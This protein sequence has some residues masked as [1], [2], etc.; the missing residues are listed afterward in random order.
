[1]AVAVIMPRQGQ[2]VESCILTQ[3]F[4][5]VG[6]VVS[7]GDLLFGYETDKAAF[8]EESP[9]DGILLA[10]YFEEGDEVPVLSN[11]AVIGKKGE[12]TESFAPEKGAASKLGTASG[13]ETGID[14]AQEADSTA[15][16][17]MAGQ[18]DASISG[19][20]VSGIS[21]RAR[22]L[23]REKRIQ[24]EFITGTGPGGRIIERDILDEISRGKRLTPLAQKKLEGQGLSVPAQGKAPYGKITS[25][26]LLTAQVGA[27]TSAPLAG[28]GPYQ[29]IPLSN[30]RKIVA[31]AMYRSLQNSAQLTHHLSA[32]ASKMLQMRKEVK[33]RM[34]DGYN[35][36]ITINDMV[37]YAVIGALREF[38]E[39]NAHFLNE[40]V[41]RF[42]QVN[43][44]MAVDT[45]R[46]LLVPAL[47]RAED[48][49]LR[50]LSTQLK[51]LADDSRSGKVSP[52]LLAPE[53]ASFTISN[54][55]NY[56]VEMFTPVINLPQVAI[57][58]VNTILHRPAILEDGSFGFQ[59]F[60]GLSLTY[61]HRA[62]DGGP[63][64][65]F[66][67]AIKSQIEKLSTELL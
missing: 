48:L 43:L 61:D 8:E 7:E 66:L 26:D 65:R 23:A 20:R 37:C 45:E 4:K 3:W 21:P 44:G 1:M 2:S 27:G 13:A 64:T 6:E 18:K 62:L 33:K 47:L 41:R 56:G 60:I 15:A 12:T 5:E 34:L 51:R 28:S 57:L 49:S 52:D 16:P 53:A 29:D 50:E 67:A 19:P 11:V 31:S 32:N 58:G 36:N 40:K 59:P 9:E 10:R 17:E 25:K 24:Y 39:A 14:S 46:G 42:S 38:P 30:V 55:G 63:A 35:S 22:K 54:L